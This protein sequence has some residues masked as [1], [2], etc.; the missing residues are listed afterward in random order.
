MKNCKK[1]TTTVFKKGDTIMK[2]IISFVIASVMA[3]SSFTAALAADT[4]ELEKTLRLVKSRI[5]DTD[6][7]E[8]FNSE[9]DDDGYS[10]YW[11]GDEKNLYVDCT[12][13]GI[14]TY[15][16]CYDYNE[17]WDNDAKFP[18]KSSDE[19][20]AVATD[21][22]KRINPDI[23]DEVQITIEKGSIRNGYSVYLKQNVGGFDVFNSFGYVS[24]TDDCQ[25]VS[26][27]QL[28]YRPLA[29]PDKS[30]FLSREAAVEAFKEKIGLRLMYS[31]YYD[32]EDNKIYY[33]VYA[34]KYPSKYISALTGEAVDPYEI[35]YSDSEYS[36]NAAGAGD[37]M[38]G[39]YLSEAEEK[40]LNN[41]SG[42]ISKADAEKA[43]R[44]NKYIKLSG[45]ELKSCRL[46]S[47]YDGRYCYNMQFGGKDSP[48]VYISLDAAT[49]E[50]VNMHQYLGGERK[51][52]NQS[53]E[54][55]AVSA[56]AGDKLDEFRYDEDDKHYIRVYDGIDVEG[57]G[58]YIEACGDYV[59]YYTISYDRDAKFPK[60]EGI[61]SPEEAA[62]KFFEQADY[63]IEL[64]PEKDKTTGAVYVADFVCNLSPY[65]GNPVNYKGE[66]TDPDSEDYG[67]GYTD[68]DDH[69]AKDIVNK[70]AE[71][72]IGFFEKEFKPDNTVTASEFEG[73]LDEVFY[74][75]VILPQYLKEKSA[76]GEGNVEIT[77]ME[78]AIIML[79]AMGADKYAD[80]DIY[81]SPFEDVTENKGY[82]ALLH[83]MGIV[84]GA[85][86][87]FRPNDRLTRAE[88]AAMIYKY[89]AR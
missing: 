31:Y 43:V 47:G 84:G 33:P 83:A 18:T 71:F 15:Y 89:L 68:M 48:Y 24:L 20:K 25:R 38:A 21:F 34:N 72:N 74:E 39:K 27:F 63:E 51:E 69:W 26:N 36:R 32:D 23:A 44:K 28:S 7:Y 78:G 6:M 53:L 30:K 60:V 55:E 80:Y 52:R 14:I 87:K 41:V 11:S 75:D 82:A 42:L 81:I 12:K 66:E 29:A 22:I 46:S 19:V 86:G 9:S 88:A 64:Y 45:M 61:I 76:D 57:D 4:S 58:I 62:D 16:G 67:I 85:D 35:M 5:G 40:E 77:R 73:L 56:F 2:K 10:F 70:L 3:L 17:K 1:E 79:K 59:T 13:D 37:E 8:N 49:G 54:K 50:I 65:T